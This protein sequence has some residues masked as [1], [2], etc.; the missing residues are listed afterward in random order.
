M[1]GWIGVDLDGTLAHFG[2]WKGIDHIGTPVP[3]MMD[4]VKK[5][6]QE[7]K[8]VKI[9]TARACRGEAGIKPVREWLK[10]FGLPELEITN[11]KDFGMIDLWDDRCTQVI[12][13][14]GRRAGGE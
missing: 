2:E 13:N 6:L 7:G 11:E 4:R 8:K 10:A 1:N 3:K 5:W 14:T 12:P 9:F